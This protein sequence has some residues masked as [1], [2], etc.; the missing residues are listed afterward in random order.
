MQEEWRDITGYEGLYQVSDLGRVRSLDRTIYCQNRW[1]DVCGR[2]YPSKILTQHRYSNGYMS[3]CLG[4]N[5][6]AFLVHR[7]VALLFIPNPLNLLEVNHKDGVRDHNVLNN[8][9]WLSSSDNKRH[10]YANIPRKKH[11]NTTAVIISNVTESLT[12]AT[13]HL[14]AEYLGVNQGSIH[15]ART[16]DHLCRGYRVVSAE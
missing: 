2:F 11:A 8:L 7:L 5:S 4:R 10:G 13:E 3:V 14:A 1:G 16:R 9:E 6:P 12:F 15:S